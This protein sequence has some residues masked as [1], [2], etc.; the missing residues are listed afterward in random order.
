MLNSQKAQELFTG[1]LGE[2]LE[3]HNPKLSEKF[4]LEGVRHLAR[5]GAKFNKQYHEVLAKVVGLDEK[6]INAETSEGVEKLLNLMTELN[7]LVNFVGL[8]HKPSMVFYDPDISDD[9]RSTHFYVVLKENSLI[10]NEIYVEHQEIGANSYEAKLNIEHE[11]TPQLVMEV[12]GGHA[13]TV[14]GE[15]KIKE[16]ALT[17]HTLRTISQEEVRHYEEQ[18]GNV[19]KMLAEELSYLANGAIDLSDSINMDDLQDLA[20]SLQV[21]RSVHK[22]VAD[23]GDATESKEVELEAL[24][25]YVD[26]AVRGYTETI[27]E[28]LEAFKEVATELDEQAQEVH[29]MDNDSYLDE[30]FDFDFEDDEDFEEEEEEEIECGVNCGCYHECELGKY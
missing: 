12:S 9:E 8:A 10:I 28:V 30:D 17:A 13:Y 23:K 3:A 4:D 18:D 24:A 29:D 14:R 25:T 2:V 27:N 16:P 5:R 15:V 22:I 11:G 6:S 21:M 20:E 19:G 26:T 1:L 7:N